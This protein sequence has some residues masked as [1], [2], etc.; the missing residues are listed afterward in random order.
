M[1]SNEMQQAPARPNSVRPTVEYIEHMFSIDGW[2]TKLLTRIGKVRILSE[3][4]GNAFRSF[5]E[6][7]IEGDSFCIEDMILASEA[8]TERGIPAG[9]PGEGVFLLEGAGAMDPRLLKT[10]MARSAPGICGLLSVCPGAELSLPDGCE[11]GVFARSRFFLLQERDAEAIDKAYAQMGQSRLVRV[12]TVL[13]DGLSFRDAN[14]VYWS[15][16][17]SALF[18]RGLVGL[19]IGDDCDDVFRDGVQAALTCYAFS[20]MKMNLFFHFP[21]DLPFPQLFT[22]ELGIFDCLSAYPVVSQPVRFAA[23]GMVSLIVPRVYPAA[24]DRLVSLRPK[25]DENR[26]LIP[27]ELKKLRA[28]L[29]EA[30]ED[31]RIKGVLPLKRNT[32]AMLDNLCGDGLTYLPERELPAGFAVLAVLS[33]DADPIGTQIGTFQLR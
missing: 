26:V 31:G 1:N 7:Y 21:E 10:L 28:F 24:G 30:K 29:A 3:R 23:G 33:A 12:G 16:P 32:P 13:T 14:G 17:R 22:A 27:E 8:G 6:N 18:P 2:G 25:T 11:I 4:Q 20:D 9:R 5:A 15:R 19:E